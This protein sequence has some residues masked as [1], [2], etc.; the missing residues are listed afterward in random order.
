VCS[1]MASSSSSA[2]AVA[3]GPSS[4]GRVGQYIYNLNE[5]DDVDTGVLCAMTSSLK[6]TVDSYVD[7][8][9]ISC[10]LLTGV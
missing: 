6:N 10:K 9:S 8:V 1:A 4:P 7:A 3:D 2:P 5:N